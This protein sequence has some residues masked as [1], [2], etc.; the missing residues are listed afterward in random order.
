MQ[1][2]CSH[3]NPQTA[4]FKNHYLCQKPGLSR[5]SNN[6]LLTTLS[7]KTFTHRTLLQPMT[8]MLDGGLVSYHQSTCVLGA[9]PRGRPG[10]NLEIQKSHKQ[11]SPKITIYRKI[12][13]KKRPSFSFSLLIPLRIKTPPHKSCGAS[14]RYTAQTD[15]FSNPRRPFLSHCPTQGTYCNIPAATKT[16]KR[17]F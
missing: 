7:T 16:H 2:P 1:H 3:K 9:P 13:T 5:L 12:V 17:Y 10:T 11:L 15:L 6:S 8:Y 4:L 14:M